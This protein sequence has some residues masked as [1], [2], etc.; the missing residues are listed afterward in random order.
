MRMF[1]RYVCYLLSRP[2]S[3]YCPFEAMSFK[4]FKRIEN[5]RGLRGGSR[6]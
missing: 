5:L 4:E 6:L 3:I 1:F 2:V